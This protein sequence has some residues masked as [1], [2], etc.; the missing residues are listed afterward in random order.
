[1]TVSVAV[2]VLFPAT[3]SNWSAAVTVA[4]FVAGFGLVTA[5][6]IDR[7]A[8]VATVTVRVDQRPVAG[9]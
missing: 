5:A 8:G 6:M 4:V 2:A 9:L 3:G 1:L 7:V